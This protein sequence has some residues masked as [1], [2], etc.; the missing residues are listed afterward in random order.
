MFPSTNWI[1]GPVLGRGSSAT[2]C[3]GIDA[4]SGKTFAVKSSQLSTA[5][6]LLR[7]QSFLSSLSS[8]HVVSYLGFNVTEENGRTLYNLYMEYAVG[9][10]V[11]D[12]IQCQGGGRLEEWKIRSYTR[13]ILLGIAYLHSVGIAHCDVKGKNVLVGSD[14]AT[15][16]ADLGCAKRLSAETDNDR[17]ERRFVGGTPAFMAPEVARGEDQGFPADVW[18]LGCT[19]VEMATGKL[20]WAAKV[21]VCPIAAVQRIGF[22]N[23]LPEFPKWLSD[24]GR[25]FLDKCLRR[26]ADERWTAK[27]LLNHPFTSQCC[28]SG[29]NDPIWRSPKCVLDKQDI[30][31][32]M[33]EEEEEEENNMTKQ[34]DTR[35][36]QLGGPSNSTEQWD[37]K[38]WIFV[39]G[40]ESTDVN[41]E[42]GMER[43]RSSS[44]SSSSSCLIVDRKEHESLSCSHSSIFL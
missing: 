34:W 8:P 27:D 33:D 1:R 5:A 14:G 4:D 3:L 11:A 26:N 7:E 18:A 22:S 31:D 32:S 17:D 44:S 19:V 36:Q 41:V 35:I 16:I 12:E 43:R 9:R 24:Q 38:E 15:K 21:D 20:P 28:G 39:R 40:D 2:V 10:S 23:E 6:F 25:D 13:G 42:E 37:D 30:W 29:K